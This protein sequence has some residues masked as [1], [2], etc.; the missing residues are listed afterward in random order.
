ME[1]QNRPLAKPAMVAVFSILA[2]FLSA[3]VSGDS[4]R[5]LAE[6][7]GCCG[8]SEAT[9]EQR[10]L[11]RS[12]ADYLGASRI[13]AKG[14]RFRFDCSGLTQAVY[15]SNGIDLLNSVDG[16]PGENGVRLIRRSLLKHGRLHS[17][18]RV[19]PG[20]VVF[21]HNTWDANRDRRVNDLWTH[22]GIVERVEA[23][24]TVVFI[25]RVSRGIERYRMNLTFPDTHRADDGTLLNDF[26]RR[27]R[28]SDPPRTHYLTGQLFAAFGTVTH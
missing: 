14:R 12:A 25:S 15:F 3:C 13:H 4:Q 11:A 5:R 18:P 26:M 28:R 6:G 17:G 16:R 21:L 23:N 20:D 19:Q 2:V 9:A 1:L 27:K 22:V 24:D 7:N 8:I 10:A